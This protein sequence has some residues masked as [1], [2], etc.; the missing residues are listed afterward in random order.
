MRSMRL[1]LSL[2]VLALGLG[3]CAIHRSSVV[4]WRF[5]HLHGFNNATVAHI[6]VG[7]KGHTGN[8]PVPLSTGARLHH[9]GCVQAST[10]AVRAIERNPAGYYVNIHSLQYPAGAVR[11]QL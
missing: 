2:V 11:A 10:A 5:S 7:R 8:V 9:R 3:G 6:H 4:C 1:V